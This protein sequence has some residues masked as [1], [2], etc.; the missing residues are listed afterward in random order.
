MFPSKF[1]RDGPGRDCRAVV[2]ES[3]AFYDSRTGVSKG[4]LV[5]GVFSRRRSL[6]R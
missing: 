4:K 1:V 2:K 5:G 6:R 3:G